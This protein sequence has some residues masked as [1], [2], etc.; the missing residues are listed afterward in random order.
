MHFDTT[1]KLSEVLQIGGAAVA[2]G[3]ASL[4]Y[5]RAQRWKRA[6]F[7]AGEMRVFV[8]DKAVARVMTM[9]DYS[10]R[11]IELFKDEEVLVGYELV[12]SALRKHHPG[13]VKYTP[14]EAAIR[15]YFDIFLGYLERF[16]AFIA[17]RLV[18]SED[19][20]PYLHYWTAVLAGEFGGIRDTDI[21]PKFWGFVDFY[22]YSGTRRLI[23]TY[24]PTLATRYPV[25]TS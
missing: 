3:V 20:Q 23:L 6:E 2:F 9:L 22:G 1:I 4:Q 8:S 14:E 16:E 11:K 18:K 7:V 17:A 24:H 15:D 10:S 21:L 19:L 5:A 12:S 25:S 13:D